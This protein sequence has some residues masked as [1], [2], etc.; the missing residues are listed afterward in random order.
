MRRWCTKKSTSS[1]RWRCYCCSHASPAGRCYLPSQSG[2][3][4]LPLPLVCVLPARTSSGRFGAILSLLRQQ[5]QS[6]SQAQRQARNS[7]H[8]KAWKQAKWL[9]HSHLFLPFARFIKIAPPPPPTPHRHQEALAI[10]PK[11]E[12][13][14]QELQV[15]V[16]STQT[17]T[18]EG[19]PSLFPF[20]PLFFVVGL[21]QT[22][23]S[24][25]GLPLCVAAVQSCQTKGDFLCLTTT[26]LRASGAS[27]CT[28]EVLDGAAVGT[29]ETVWHS[30][31]RADCK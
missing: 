30:M 15:L 18:D 25:G 1:G 21:P 26:A 3:Y 13:K 8:A 27:R 4:S 7:R 2:G 31:E 22:G 5:T 23:S 11:H 19:I 6:N 29:V 16:P 24:G 28:A 14:M 10:H 20:L 9:V 12:W 17:T